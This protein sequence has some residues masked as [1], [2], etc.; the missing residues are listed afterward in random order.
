MSRLTA[1]LLGITVAAA[2][3]SVVAPAHAD[4]NQPITYKWTANKARFS[5]RIRHIQEQIDMGQSKGWLTAEQ[6]AKF[7][8]EYDKEAAM[9]QDWQSKGCPDSG[10][11]PLEKEVTATHHFLHAAIARGS[12]KDLTPAASAPATT[13]TVS[14]KQSRGKK[15]AGH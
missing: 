6:F 9:E 15:T 4:M 3:M 14:T 13:K 1:T 8:A 2:G 7:K 11:E 5:D 12:E 10:I